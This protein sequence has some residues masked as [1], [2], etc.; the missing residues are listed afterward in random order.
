V[1]IEMKSTKEGRVKVDNM[2]D[3]WRKKVIGK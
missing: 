2:L 3:W 1:K